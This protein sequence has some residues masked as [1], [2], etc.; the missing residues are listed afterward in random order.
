MKTDVVNKKSEESKRTQSFGLPPQGSATES[1]RTVRVGTAAAAAAL[2]K[3]A[4]AGKPVKES[5]NPEMR[6]IAL[7]LFGAAV[8]GQAQVQTIS[9]KTAGAQRVNGYFSFWWD[10]K[11]GR[12]LLEADKLGQEF[13]YVNSLPAGIGS[14]DIGLDR[15]QLGASR[16]VKFERAGNKLLLVEP[17]YGF[18][19]LSADPFERR[20]VEES[21]ATS[22]IWGF[23]IEASDGGRHLIDLTPFLMRDAHGVSGALARSRQGTY[24]VEMSR[25]AVNIAKTKGFP[26]NSEF[27]AILTFTGEPQGMYVRQVSPSPD[28]ITVRQ[29]HSFIQLPEPGYQT[30]EFDP[31]GGFFGGSYYDFATPIDQ[32]LIK[33]F[34]TRHRL[35]KGGR[36]T[37]YLDRGAPEPVRSA[38]LE[39]ARW[40]SQAFEAAGF[41]DAFHVELLPEDADSM[42]VRYNVIQWVHRSTRGWSYGNS[43]RDPRTGEILKGHVTLDSLRVRQDFLIGEGLLAPYEAGRPIDPK[44][45]EMCLARLR[46]LSAHEV[47][48]TL[49]LS[50]SYAASSY[51]RG[52]VMDYPH[53]LLTLPGGD[54]APDASDAYGTGIGEWD[55]VAVTW[56]Y[57]DLDAGGRRK[58]LDDAHK[59]GIYYLTDADGRPEGSAHPHTHL[60]DNGGDPVTEL[61][62]LMALRQRVLT[63]FGEKSIPMWAPMATLEDALVPAYFMTRYQTEAA[64]KLIGGLD[65]RYAVR[66]DGQLV[67]AMVAPEKQRAALES[68]IETLR[69]GYLALP[70]RILKLIPPRP[71]GYA[72]TRE[73][74]QGRTGLTFDSLAP[75]EAMA[76]DTLRLLLNAE[77]AAR[78]VE[79]KGRDASQPGLEEVLTRVL[80]MTSQ[81]GEVGHTVRHAVI[82]HVMSLAANESASPRVRE[83]TVQKL[84][85]WAAANPALSRDVK[86]FLDNPKDFKIARPLEPPPGQPIGMDCASMN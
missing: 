31:R 48:H 11:S 53:P 14:N 23:P 1:T 51:G 38:L 5:D 61:K 56:G 52:S 54:G 72:S 80:A 24:R 86:R 10:E 70:E 43:V 65:Y 42:D 30:R 60:W 45:M 50:H 77:R 28:A 25:S 7:L 44:V 74:F 8:H 58:V 21:F 19:A 18:R 15:G 32:P 85:A 12:V 2:R 3:S 33:R 69:T 55:K 41:K 47:G 13:L 73:L 20:A 82:A 40:W 27:D 78:L 84:S 62:R 57:G 26:R 64:I 36:I 63:R 75:A 76:N 66:G 37:Y 17:N 29:H 46:Q 81:P 67:T 59:R 49:G 39:G 22:V 68:A 34:I 4:R 9:Q 71:S 16:I 79:Y 35:Q 83:I 6:V